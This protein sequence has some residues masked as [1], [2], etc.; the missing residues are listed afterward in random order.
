[1]ATKTSALYF[2]LP[3]RSSAYRLNAGDGKAES[4]PGLGRALHPDSA[5][6]RFDETARNRQPQPGAPLAAVRFGPRAFAAI[7]AVEDFQQILFQNDH[8]AVVDVDLNVIAC[9]ARREMNLLAGGGVIHCII[10]QVVKH[11]QDLIG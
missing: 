11:P 2:W 5:V 7:E 1:M 3:G 9:A 10:D 8:P 4:G 6:V